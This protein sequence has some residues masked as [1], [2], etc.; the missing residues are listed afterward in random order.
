[1][2]KQRRTRVDP[3]AGGL[4]ER[5]TTPFR[6]EKLVVSCCATSEGGDCDEGVGQHSG[7]GL[8]LR[9]RE[10]RATERTKACRWV[11]VPLFIHGPF[12]PSARRHIPQYNTNDYGLRYAALSFTCLQPISVQSSAASPMVPAYLRLWRRRCRPALHETCSMSKFL[13]WQCWI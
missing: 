8:R 5:V 4:F 6:D 3:L 9:S 10:R 13:P 1:M 12:A 11:P 2:G 7:T